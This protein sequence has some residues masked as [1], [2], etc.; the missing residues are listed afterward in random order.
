V[1]R[2]TTLALLECGYDAVAWIEQRQQTRVAALSLRRLP[3]GV[4]ASV[5]AG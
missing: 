3:S 5:D 4:A 1:T 2:T